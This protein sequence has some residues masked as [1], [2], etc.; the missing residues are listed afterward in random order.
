[1]IYKYTVEYV[2]G[3]HSKEQNLCSQRNLT[4]LSVHALTARTSKAIVC[5]CC[6]PGGCICRSKGG[7]ICRKKSQNPLEYVLNIAVEDVSTHPYFDQRRTAAT[8]HQALCPS[9]QL[10][11]PRVHTLS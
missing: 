10:D 6:L 3:R 8:L 11:M 1:M 2:K 4:A 9:G 7:E 5:K